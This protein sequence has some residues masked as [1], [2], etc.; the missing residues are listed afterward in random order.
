MSSTYS[1]PVLTQ[2]ELAFISEMDFT[3]KDLS[4]SVDL[5]LE[6]D[7]DARINVLLERLGL[8]SELKLVAQYHEQQLVF[9]VC[10]AQGE[11]GKFS[12]ELRSPEIFESG[13]RLR[14]WRHRLNTPLVAT[15]Q[16]TQQQYVLN[17]LSSTGFCLAVD[18]DDATKHL[19]LSVD[20]PDSQD[21]LNFNAYKVRQSHQAQ[22]AYT[23]DLDE[24]QRDILR[25]FLFKMHREY[26]GSEINVSAERSTKA[27]QDL[28][29]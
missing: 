13:E 24:P 29:A 25:R 20:L 9:P 26:Y 11:F 2:D 8:A 10:I 12:M 7:D 16:Q 18:F 28:I 23:I 19:E 5:K 14:N 22:T 27:L 15:C 4:D 17:E 1:D 6:L 21:V 3:Q